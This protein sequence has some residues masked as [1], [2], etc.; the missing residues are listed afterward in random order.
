MDET[1][2]PRFSAT[3]L[4]EIRSDTSV[5]VIQGARQVGKSTL[6]Q[7]SSEAT[8][9]TFVT[10]D[11]PATLE[12][13][14][15]DPIRFLQQRQGKTL[16]IDEIQRAP[17]LILPL[18]AEVDRDRKPGR[19]I[20]TGSADLL[21]TPGVGDSLAGRAETLHLGPLSQ[22][23]ILRRPSPEDFVSTILNRSGALRE[24]TPS[25]LAT[26][27]VTTGGYPL[28]VSRTPRRQVAWFNSY[29]ERLATHD[30][31]EIAEGKY[32]AHF[33]RLIRTIA[34]DGLS[35]LVQVKVA[36]TL[37]I[38]PTTLSAYLDLMARMHLFVEIPSWGRSIHS[39]TVRRPKVALCDTGLSAALAGFTPA[40]ANQVGGREYFGALVEQFVAL[41][42]LK[43]RTWSEVPFD[44]FH[45][46]DRD[47]LEVDLVAETRDG[48]L[49]A[50]EVK[51]SMTPTKQH[52]GNLERFRERF[53]DRQITG[54]LLHGGTHTATMHEWLHI[55]PVPAL[56]SV[57]I[58]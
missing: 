27:A 5:V 39:R 43:Q 16:V 15:V 21:T 42:L 47:G 54:V 19:F 11:D 58:S 57:P 7:M 44:L 49:V 46:R 2:Y 18:K 6:T 12:Y 17:S 3:L 56:W 36:R 20:L 23:E 13:A 32:A 31:A 33:T 26:D 29:V 38:S 41:E 4:E 37:D 10:L 28:V 25:A 48:R 55:L 24:V 35:E 1:F 45:Y 14:V 53:K 8:S 9:T 51:T 52:W 50:I 40:D 30:A 34:A 22:G